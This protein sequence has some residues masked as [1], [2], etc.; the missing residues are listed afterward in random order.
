MRYRR[1][2]DGLRAVAV[3]PVILF[4]A[5]L[6]ALGGGFV[7][8]DVFFVISGYLITSI[9]LAEATAG[10]FTLAGFYERRARRILPALFLVLAASLPAAW[11]WLAPSD[12][13]DFGKSLI[14]VAI[15]SSN[16]LFWQQSGY[17][18]TAAELKPLLHTWSLAVEE[19]YYL[20]FPPLVMLI[21]RLARRR[22]GWFLTVLGLLS[23]AA[24]EARNVAAPAATFFLLPTRGW[25]LL[26]GALIALRHHGVPPREDASWPAQAL[27]LGGLLAILIAVFAFD[28]RTPFPGIA[29]LLPVGGTVAVIAGANPVTL[30]GRLLGSRLLVG[31]GLLSY[32]AYLWHQPL[33]AFAR[34]A[35]LEKPSLGLFTG[36]VLLTFGLAYLSWRFVEK[37]FRRRERFTRRRIFVLAALGSLIFIVVGFACQAANH[38]SHYRL[39]AEQAT[40]IAS[41]Q[42]SPL[43]EKCHT[44][45]ADYLKPAAAC[46]F[47]APDVRW[48]VLGDSHAVELAYALAK[49]LEP[50]GIGIKQLSF[51]G[52]PPTW[53]RPEVHTDCARWTAEAVDYLI[54]T[55][56]IDTVV[57]SY[58]I[59]MHLYG[60]HEAVYP[61]L[62]AGGSDAERA[63]I[64]QAYGNLLGRL[65]AAGKRVALVLQA[66]ELPQRATDMI[67]K[68]RHQFGDLAGV[69]TAWWQRR[70]AWVRAHRDTLPAG[71]S[72]IDPTELL[73]DAQ[74]CYV[75]R[76]GQ[77]LYFDDDHLSVT[78]AGL[79]AREILV[80][81]NRSAQDLTPTKVLPPTSPN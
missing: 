12:L 46:T 80:R 1:E 35:S 79:V 73:C 10:N 31:C 32:S 21:W 19:Q 77:A 42:R 4:H 58:R 26:A 74:N 59:N 22:L 24:A 3:L 65:Q 70:N 2:I 6:P 20:L 56:R 11:L 29:A 40:L 7:G 69:P 55:P 61:E 27:G 33:F 36:L 17:F 41:A 14:G 72:V 75:T 57:V 23:L 9:I 37:P 67:F 68:H 39:S 8:V 5:G 81:A 15:F 62:P 28:G 16:F 48:A 13:K 45:H 64:W 34:H 53:G 76:Q 18:D 50:S 49:A 47:F 38:L 63:A 52:C 25:E 54:A 44:S 78:G 30:A 43:R 51:A 71:I 66:P 60:E